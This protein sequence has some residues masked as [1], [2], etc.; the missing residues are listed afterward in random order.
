MR[1]TT[2]IF[3]DCLT[4][5]GENATDRA[6]IECVAVREQF[7]SHEYTRTIGLVI[8]GVM[9]FAMQVNKY[10]CLLVCVFVRCC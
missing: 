8:S 1:T 2:L 6:L 3:T 10:M 5:L 9:V 7:V 4:E